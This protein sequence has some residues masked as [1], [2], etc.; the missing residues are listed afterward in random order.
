MS[1]RCSIIISFPQPTASNRITR[2][3]LFSSTSSS[4]NLHKSKRRKIE[5]QNKLYQT[6]EKN[7]FPKKRKK[8]TTR[9]SNNN[10]VIKNDRFSLRRIPSRRCLEDSWMK[11]CQLEDSRRPIRMPAI[12]YSRATQSMPRASTCHKR[13]ERKFRRVR[14]GIWLRWRGAEWGTR[15]VP[16]DNTAVSMRQVL[17]LNVNASGPHWYSCTRRNEEQIPRG[18]ETEKAAATEMRGP[19]PAGHR[20]GGARRSW[21]WNATIR[22]TA[23]ACSNLSAV[24]HHRAEGGG[25]ARQGDRGGGRNRFIAPPSLA[26]PLSRNSFVSA[27]FGK[28]A[29]FRDC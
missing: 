11:R 12:P 3:P 6:R 20:G 27:S 21:L 8:I 10:R 9:S 13:G 25:Q 18:Y 24:Y 16:S 22:C 28:T 26:S 2:L 1:S 7:I 4:S 29:I 17:L 23:R 15:P 19:F 14:H 5:N